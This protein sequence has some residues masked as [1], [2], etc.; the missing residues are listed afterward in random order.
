MSRM[1]DMAYEVCV[2]LLGVYYCWA[3]FDFGYLLFQFFPFKKEPMWSF[4]II[5]YYLDF[6]NV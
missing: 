1:D 6:S 5:I 3:A 4:F 2:C